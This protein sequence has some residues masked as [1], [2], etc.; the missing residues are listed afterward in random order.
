MKRFAPLAAGVV[1]VVGC[2]ALGLYLNSLAEDKPKATHPHFTP[3]PGSPV[4]VGPMAQK[5]LVAD[6]NGDG[7]L[8]VVLTCGGL[9]QNKP[10]PAK[11][12]VAVLSGDGRGRFKLAQ[13]LLPIGAGGLK[14]AVGDV[15]GDG[16]PDIVVIAHDS[17]AVTV[18]LQDDRGR[19]D[20]NRRRTVPAGQAG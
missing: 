11:G 3:A 20:A 5:L 1:A 12:F 10:D 19:F 13:S 14:A 4:A 9:S 6:M 18:L 15:N 17:D 8:D 7:N 16:R 2:V